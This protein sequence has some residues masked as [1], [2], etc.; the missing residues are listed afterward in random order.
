[1]I[2]FSVYFL[3]AFTFINLH[4]VAAAGFIPGRKDSVRRVSVRAAKPVYQTVRISGET[5]RIDGRLDDD[6][7]TRDGVWSGNYT[8][9]M[10]EEGAAPSQETELKILYDDANIYVAIRAYDTEPEKIDFRPAERDGFN[11]DMVGLA[12]DS[13]HDQRT[14][15]EFNLTASG[16]KIDL[17]LMNDRYDVNWNAVWDG[18]TALED[19]AW[20]AEFRIPLSQLRY[21]NRLEQEWGLHAWRWLSRNAEESQWALIPRDAPARLS[22]IGTLTGLETKK[23]SRRL[24]LLPYGLAMAER[25]EKEPGNPFAKGYDHRFSGGLDAKIGLTTD[26]TMDVTV[27]P[28][29]GQVE[30]D[31]SVLNLSAFE[32][33]Y[34]ERR[35]FFLEGNN[36]LSLDYSRSNQLFYSRRIGRT[37]RHH[38]SLEEGEYAS[39]PGNTRIIS[40]VKVTGKN[41]NGL[42]V[43]VMQSVTARE[44]AEISSQEGTSRYETVEPLTSYSV[45]RLQRDMNEA[46]TIVGGMITATNRDLANQPHLNHIPGS[47]YTGGIDFRHQWKDKTYF[48]DFKG[49][50]SHVS[51][52]STA[53][54]S[55]QHNSA[56]YMQ[57][58]DFPHL[59]VDSSLTSMAGTGGELSI[60][61]AG[62]GR[63]RYELGL[64]TGSP[65]LELNDIGF[66]RYTDMISQRTSLSYVITDPFSIFRY[67]SSS[68]RLSNYW[69]MGGH[70]TSS[71]LSG[72]VMS[73]FANKWGSMLSLTRRF[74]GLQTR[75]LRGGPA[76]LKPG[77][78]EYSAGLSSD[79]SKNIHFRFFFDSET[80]D[81]GISSTFLYSPA[82]TFRIGNSIEISS[83]AR[84]SREKENLQY[85]T[86][87]K[88]DSD[89]RYI[90]GYLDRK[91]MS[92]TLRAD[93]GIT[94]ELTIQYYGSPYLSTGIYDDFKR[95][96]DS[97][98]ARY[99][100]R[101]HT[102]SGQEIQLD[103]E[104]NV[105]RIDENANG[106][107]DYEFSNPDFNFRQFRSNLVARWE[108]RPGSILYLVWQHSRTGYD[109]VT[110]PSLANNMGHLWDIYPTDILMLKLNY[111]FSL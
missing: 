3:I 11:G 63:W 66:L 100:D 31:P 19:S 104:G 30:A 5:P 75:E 82:L 89:P 24:E 65:K 34:E 80:S 109:A 35:P 72:S 2:R 9:Q 101:F 12:F 56:R 85:V 99:E 108:Y 25:S 76:L 70:Y 93:Y 96:T 23:K 91:T 47:A 45:V 43:G 51:G 50:F 69:N 103:P 18:K 46:N 6:C 53:I 48:V 10:P 88:M 92:F 4:T 83:S 54:T 87:K 27:N 71:R 84:Y 86:R 62:N 106:N 98:A 26:F 102:F 107:T 29:F 57:R 33:F 7:W 81:D 32:V 55:L 77:Q 28:D 90:M 17:L 36:I 68:L 79:N 40:A 94:P 21:A 44:I 1:M 59:G 22:E 49:V 73:Q 67:F 37:P 64:S 20:T 15:F 13:Y 61:K 8:Q 14:A 58:P 95:I 111:W 39:A 105:Y 78:W 38:P 60:G 41:R 16:G 110:D 52:D 97:R 42:S 74:E